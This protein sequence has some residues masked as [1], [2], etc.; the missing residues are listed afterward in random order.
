[1]ANCIGDYMIFFEGVLCSPKAFHMQHAN[2]IGS[3]FFVADS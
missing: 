1:M 3:G 2:E